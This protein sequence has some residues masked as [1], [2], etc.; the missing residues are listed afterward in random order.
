MICSTE[1]AAIKETNLQHKWQIRCVVMWAALCKM[2]W[3]RSLNAAP[4]ACLAN[5]ST[6]WNGI[7]NRFAAK[8]KSL[9]TTVACIYSI[10]FEIFFFGVPFFNEFFSS[11]FQCF[12]FDLHRDASTWHIHNS[13]LH[14]YRWDHK[15]RWHWL[16]L[17]FS[18]HAIW[19]RQV[20][21]EI[22]AVAESDE[23]MRYC[24]TDARTNTLIPMQPHR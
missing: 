23:L 9:G 20:K 19:R 1:V 24:W 6:V 16:V 8:V 17:Y 10:Y 7:F 2:K 21:I 11:K 3:V 18:V 12:K 14:A 15:S 22:I 5:C 4:S 13:Q